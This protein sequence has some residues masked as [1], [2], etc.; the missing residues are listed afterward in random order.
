MRRKGVR[1]P[2][3]ILVLGLVMAGLAGVIALELRS[4]EPASPALPAIPA[5][6]DRNA[7]PAAVH[8][9]PGNNVLA[10]VHTILARPLFTPSRRPDEQATGAGASA[11]LTR[12]TGIVV[13]EDGKAAIFAPTAGGKP[14]IVREG[15]RIGPYVVS[16]ISAGA[17]TV[18]GPD[19]Q[20]V[21]HPAFDPNPPARPPSPPAVKFPLPRQGPG[22]E[23]K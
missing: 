17:L 11:G 8:A 21:L 9:A 19:G 1:L 13:S 6:Q 5:R 2:Y 20:R 23:A 7:A 14:L 16:A 18:I 15:D 3:G 10:R 22:A 4:G 12:L